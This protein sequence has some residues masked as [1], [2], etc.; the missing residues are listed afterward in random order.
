VFDALAE[1]V[2]A[3]AGTLWGD[4][5]ELRAIL[6]TGGGAV[7]LGSRIQQRYPHARVLDDPAMAN[8]KGFQKYGTRKWRSIE[9]KE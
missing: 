6:I 8:V 4:G 3:Q 9:A 7:A 1:E 2:L 5:R